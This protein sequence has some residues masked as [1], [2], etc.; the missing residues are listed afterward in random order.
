MHAS[1]IQ[2]LTSDTF[3]AFSL[4]R[5]TRASPPSEELS[6]ARSLQDLVTVLV[7]LLVA[8]LH[9][10]RS[11]SVTL[12]SRMGTF[13]WERQMRRSLRWSVTERD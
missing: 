10:R 5:E 13:Q 1:R 8:L 3:A 6:P 4:Q 9:H 7:A 12:G 11:Y 2:G